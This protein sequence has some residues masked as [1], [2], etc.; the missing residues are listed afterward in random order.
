MIVGTLFNMCRGLFDRLH[1]VSV[2]T[3][4]AIYIT[5]GAAFIRL[6]LLLL[7][8]PPMD[9]DQGTMGI[10]A[11]HIFRGTDFPIFFYGQSYMGTLEAYMAAGFFHL[12]GISVFSLRIGLILFYIGFLINS[13]FITKKLF[14]SKFAIFILVLES[15]G[16]NDIVFREMN[17][18]GGYPEIFFFVTLLWLIALELV[19][20]ASSLVVQ[21]LS[22]RR[23]F[24]YSFFVLVAEFSIYNDPLILPF[25][26]FSVI[27]ILFYCYKEFSLPLILFIC[28]MFLFGLLPSI[29]TSGTAI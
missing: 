20:P 24:L 5:A 7:G 28:A 14:S 3:R 2:Y 21:H 29:Y 15:L 19:L 18:Q 9:S 4:I 27:I 11:I 26:F 10:A 8:W 12:F 17:A 1:A 6:L 16:A 25:I 22:W 13:F 23:F